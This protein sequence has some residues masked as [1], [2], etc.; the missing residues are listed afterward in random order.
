[1]VASAV[2]LTALAIFLGSMVSGMSTSRYAQIRNETLDD[3]R[4][5]SAAFTKDARQ[6]VK[7]RT[8]LIDQVVMDTYVN[9]TLQTVTWRVV[10]E[11]GV[12]NLRRDQ[13]GGSRVFDI[14][15]TTDAV[16]SYYREV[17]PARVNRMRLVLATQPDPKYPPVQVE[18]DAEMRNAL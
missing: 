12:L 5:T 4:L 2:L 13:N 10:N 6:A 14:H 1:M 16:F 8:A 11:G 18:A 7:V 3:L 9:G 17:D 15:L